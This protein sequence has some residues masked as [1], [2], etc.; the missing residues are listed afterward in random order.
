[1][2]SWDHIPVG[3]P[4]QHP[5]ITFAVKSVESLSDLKQFGMLTM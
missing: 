4:V 1:M 3:Y 5:K 2:S